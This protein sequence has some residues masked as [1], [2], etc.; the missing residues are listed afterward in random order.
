MGFDEGSATFGAEV[1]FGQPDSDMT[2]KDVRL[3]L[4]FCRERPVVAV[5]TDERSYTFVESLK[6][7]I[8]YDFISTKF[9]VGFRR[10]HKKGPSIF[11]LLLYQI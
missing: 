6:Q 10:H 7:G 8:N 1:I 2:V 4:T 9:V 3:E 11:A 5:T